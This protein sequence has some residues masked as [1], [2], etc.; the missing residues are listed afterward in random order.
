MFNISKT[1]ASGVR[2]WRF[3]NIRYRQQKSCITVLKKSAL[4]LAHSQKSDPSPV[5]FQLLGSG[6]RSTALPYHCEMC[7]QL[8]DPMRWVYFLGLDQICPP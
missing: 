8:A 5:Q 1:P 6:I 4:D 7:A 2:D 3:F